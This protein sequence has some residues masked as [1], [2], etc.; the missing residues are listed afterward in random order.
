MCFKKKSIIDSEK[1]LK[2]IEEIKNN[3][4]SLSIILTKN[5]EFCKIAY[6]NITERI[7]N[8]ERR[9]NDI[10]SIIIKQNKPKKKVVLK[11]A[12]KVKKIEEDK[13]E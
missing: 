4:N 13:D 6:D 10:K 1:L 5:I 3:V 9:Q 12:A 8:I 2:E 11:R 7:I